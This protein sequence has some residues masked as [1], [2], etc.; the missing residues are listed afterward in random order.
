M[1][2]EIL[3]S[4]LVMVHLILILIYLTLI[5]SNIIIDTWILL[6]LKLS[7][8][9][10]YISYWDKNN[11]IHCLQAH[12]CID[13]VMEWLDGNLLL[14]GTGQGFDRPSVKSLQHMCAPSWGSRSKLVDWRA[15]TRPG[16]PWHRRAGARRCL[17]CG[18]LAHSR[19]GP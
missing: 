10:S 7:R 11:L 6:Y 9:S 18:L 2:D 17:I 14:L 15:V 1:L 5:F 12:F 4:L 19:P 16:R 8:W 13:F 3:L